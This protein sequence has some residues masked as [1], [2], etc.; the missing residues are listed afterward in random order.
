M[1]YLLLHLLLIINYFLLPSSQ[2]LP[3][4]S[5]TFSYNSEG[6]ALAQNGN[7]QF[8]DNKTVLGTLF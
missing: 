8:Q 7:L 5:V 1:Y 2:F 4:T 6:K 3:Q